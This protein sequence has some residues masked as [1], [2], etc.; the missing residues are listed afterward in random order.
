MTA[1]EANR[2]EQQGGDAKDAQQKR[3][4]PRP[5]ERAVEHPLERLDA[6]HLN[7]RIDGL[8]AAACERCREIE[9]R[10]G[11]QHEQLR[12]HEELRALADR[13]SRAVLVSSRYRV[14]PATPTIVSHR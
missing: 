4:E 8:H 5:R 11:S 14:E 3:V 10:G 12:R 2:R 13:V 9:R 6:H 1:G 7:G